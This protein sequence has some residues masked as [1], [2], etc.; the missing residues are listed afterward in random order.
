MKRILIVAAAVLL[1][2]AVLAPIA[3]ARTNYRPWK[4]ALQTAAELY[5]DAYYNPE[6]GL[7]FAGD[8]ISIAFPLA[9][10]PA[11][12]VAPGNGAVLGARHQ[13]RSCSRTWRTRA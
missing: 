3:S 13:L 6:A 10:D 5:S 9:F 8:A 1:A 7:D 12:N 4:H 2:G 11:V